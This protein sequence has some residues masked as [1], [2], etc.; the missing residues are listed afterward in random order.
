ML[1]FFGA[2]SS[3]QISK[4]SL[5]VGRSWKKFVKEKKNKKKKKKKKKMR[6]GQKKKER[7]KERNQ[8]N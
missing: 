7:K 6:E 2:D 8:T 3:N 5:H 4:I 1:T